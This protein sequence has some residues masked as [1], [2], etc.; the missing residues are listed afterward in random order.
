MSDATLPPIPKWIPAPVTQEKLDYIELSNLD[1]ADFDNPES[2]KKLARQFYEAFTQEGFVTLSGHGISKETWD[3]QMDL[4]NATMT[5]DPKAKVS[6]EAGGLG[7][8]K[9]VSQSPASF[10]LA[11]H[12]TSQIDFYNMLYQDTKADRQHPPHLIPYL[13]ETRKVMLH[14]RDDIQRKLFILLAMC[15]EMPVDHLMATHAPGQSSSE[16]YR[17]MSYAPLTPEA[18]AKARGLFM[19]AHA[20]WGTFSILFSQPVAALQI[21]HKSGVFKWVEYKPYTLIVNVGQALELL[22]GGLFP[23]TIH[24]VVTPPKDQVNCLRVGI[25]YFSRPNDDYRLF[26]FPHS[27]VLKRLG[28]D[29]PLDRNVIYNTVEF[30]EA[31]K[32]G[33]LKPELDFDKPKDKD[34]HDDPFRQGDRF[35]VTEKVLASITEISA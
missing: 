16:Y 15:L 11:K 22:T 29:K 25:Y 26:P 21:L 31:K 13:D 4:C 23:A 14:V 27:P 10:E 3:Q 30:L 33:Y 2:R 9:E 5:M 34:L 1:L 19:P 12:S 24:R 35:A 18:T 6:F 20:D 17:Y 7:F 32:H 28:K 8:H